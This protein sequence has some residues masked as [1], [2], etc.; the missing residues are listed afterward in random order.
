MLH[1]VR[2]LLGDEATEHIVEYLDGSARSA[3]SVQVKG[4][5]KAL[6]TP[7]TVNC[8]SQDTPGESPRENSD[9]ACLQSEPIDLISPQKPSV[10]PAAKVD[11]AQTP[12]LALLPSRFAAQS[13]KAVPATT[14]LRRRTLSHITETSDDLNLPLDSE[15]SKIHNFQLRTI[16][17]SLAPL[18]TVKYDPLLCRKYLAELEGV[19]PRRNTRE[20]A[21]LAIMK[22]RVRAAIGRWRE[23]GRLEKQDVRK[24]L[25]FVVSAQDTR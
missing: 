14:L 19:Y 3:E 17:K 11:K 10:S 12:F 23:R 6:Y 15:F 5:L 9:P 24:V 22:D 4:A 2:I 8:S 21:I 18:V 1:R 7:R 25:E 13:I 16:V 20:A